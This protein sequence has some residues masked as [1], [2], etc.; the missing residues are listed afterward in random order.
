MHRSG[1]SVVSRLLNL[2]GVNL[3]SASYL[4][5]SGPDNPKGYWEH[6]GFV[7]INDQVLAAFS[8]RWDCPPAFPGGWFRAPE[9]SASR[10]QAQRLLCDEFSS[11]PLWGWKDPRTSL[12]LPFWQ[13]LIGPMRYVIPVRNP[14]AVV[15]SLVQR[16]QMAPLEAEWLWLV[17]TQAILAATTGHPRLF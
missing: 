12:T 1:T 5:A 17:H 15:A 13:D 14:L 2:L 8:G 11:T 7:E 6:R 3:G 9:L 16:N 4:T 10:E